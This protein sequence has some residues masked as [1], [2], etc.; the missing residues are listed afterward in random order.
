MSNLDLEKFKVFSKQFFGIELTK[1]Q[2]IMFENVESSK[3]L[4][5]KSARQKGTTTFMSLYSFF[6]SKEIDNFFIEIFCHSRFQQK[7]FTNYNNKFNYLETLLEDSEIDFYIKKDTNNKILFSNNSNIIFN[8][9]DINTR[10]ASTKNL[11][12]IDNYLN[13]IN[14]DYVMNNSYACVIIDTQSHLTN[15]LILSTFK[16]LKIF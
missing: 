13:N 2:E 5:I 4:L 11:T 7:I 12:I 15:S 9:T 6:K 3:K 1:N 14:V 8:S 16:E 10:G